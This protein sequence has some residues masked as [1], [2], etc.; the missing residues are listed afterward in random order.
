MP[1]PLLLV[2]NSSFSNDELIRYIE[3]KSSYLSRESMSEPFGF[4]PPS[5]A[6]MVIQTSVISAFFVF[7]ADT[8]GKHLRSSTYIL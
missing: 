2:S 3:R 7:P 4:R 5:I 1:G 8:T 6:L